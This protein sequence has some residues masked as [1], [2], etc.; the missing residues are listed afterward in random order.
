M[1][2][3]VGDS[4][5]HGH[6]ASSE[7]ASYPAQLE[8]L[9]RASGKGE[10]RVVNR[11]WAGQNSWDVLSK[12]EDQLR[13]FRPRLVYVLVGANDFWSSPTIHRPGEKRSDRFPIRCR[14]YRLLSIVWHR[15]FGARPAPERRGPALFSPTGNLLAD[16]WNAL[17]AGEIGIAQESFRARIRQDPSDPVARVGLIQALVDV[18]PKGE[19]AELLSWLREYHA[20]RRDRTSYEL[21]VQALGLLGKREECLRLA[22]EA[23][24]EH[25]DSLDGWEAIA[26][27]T[28]LTDE[29]DL[30]I[31]AADRA[32]SLLTAEGDPR[33]SPLVR[34]R[35]Y[36][37]QFRSRILLPVDPVRSLADVFEVFRLDGD[38]S[39]AIGLFQ[40][41]RAAYTQ[42]RFDRALA[43]ARLTEAQRATLRRLRSEALAQGDAERR[44]VL[45]AN[46][47]LA[48]SLCSAEGAEGVLLTYPL[49]Q[50]VVESVVR[51]ISE[52]TGCV[53]LDLR[54]EFERLLQTRKPSELF[55]P[56]GH[57]NDAGYGVMAGVVAA[58]VLRRPP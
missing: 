55:I 40:M 18:D 46:L 25:P 34:R 38:E 52:S 1:I 4:F 21:L 5:T 14:T 20:A 8:T 56:D 12:L 16:G 10:W 54:P 42:E 47:R 32:L 51:E 30:S 45:E 36:L 2:L 11:G 50:P 13:T 33:D 37:L 53:W 24:R 29:L 26:R 39:Q 35:V 7:A 6:G 31:E 3:C 15:L 28:F 22:R 23:V 49:S 58:D 57:C 9:L 27:Q 43:E 41:G 19:Q 17:L 44:R 48:L